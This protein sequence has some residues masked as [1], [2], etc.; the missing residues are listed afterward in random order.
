MARRKRRD[1]EIVCMCIAY[2]HP[3]RLGGGSCTGAGWCQSFREIDS[4]ECQQCTMQRDDD[5]C[6][7]VTGLEPI[8]MERCN[9][10][11]EECRSRWIEHEYGYLP[12]NVPDYWDKIYRDYYDHDNAH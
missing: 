2:M 12:L 4:F 9:C 11:A 8:N 3:H 10:V 1:N 7:V 5:T 6:D